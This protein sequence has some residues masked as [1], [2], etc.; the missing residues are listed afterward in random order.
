MTHSLDL[1]HFRAAQRYEHPLPTNEV[2]AFKGALTP[3][4]TTSP[5]STCSSFLDK[6]SSF[7]ETTSSILMP[8]L[9]LIDY[10]ATKPADTELFELHEYHYLG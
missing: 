8:V 7:R 1:L 10:S 2:F 3:L 4:A 6:G 5:E 9:P